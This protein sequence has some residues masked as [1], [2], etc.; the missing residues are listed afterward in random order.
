MNALE[1]I[2]ELTRDEV[3]RRKANGGV[4]VAIPRGEAR[5]F[6]DAL[7]KP[8]LCVIAEHRRRSPSAGTIR[9]DLDRGQQHAHV[10]A[11]HRSGR[12]VA[13]LGVA[14]GRRQQRVVGVDEADAFPAERHQPIQRRRVGSQRRRAEQEGLLTGPFILVEQHHHQTGSAAEAA[15]Q[16]AL[17]DAGGRGDVVHGDGVGAALGDQPAG[18]LK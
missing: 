7:P 12:A 10:R 5:S 16:R 14:V 15:E 11:V 17:A 13:G 1:R 6:A 18:G 8:G 3:A 2:V 9:A 4:T